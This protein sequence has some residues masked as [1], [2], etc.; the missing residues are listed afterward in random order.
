MIQGKAP[1]VTRQKG[2]LDP[3]GLLSLEAQPFR[4]LSPRDVAATAVR[5][6]CKGPCD[7]QRR[8]TS[9][10][11]VSCQGGRDPAGTQ[12][13]SVALASLLRELLWGCLGSPQPPKSR[14]I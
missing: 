1:A 4:S 14:Y 5:V 6:F 8:E 9:P 10:I 12:T 11:F 13:L 2:D 3:F 7:L